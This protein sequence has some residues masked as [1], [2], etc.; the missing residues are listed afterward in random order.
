MTKNVAGRFLLDYENPD[1]GIG[2]S[3]GHINNAYKT[4]MRN[5][6]IFG[7]SRRQLV[8]STKDDWKWKWQQAKRLITG[9][10]LYET[11]NLGNSINELFNF[12]D[13]I[14]ITREKVEALIKEKGLKVIELPKPRIE[15][16]SNYQNDWDVYQEIDQIISSHPENGVVFILPN[17][18]TG[19]FEYASSRD[20]FNQCY[21]NARSR[22]P[23]KLVYPKDTLSIAVHIRRGDLLPGRQ[24]SDLADRMLPDL[25]Y[26]E[27]IQKILN[28]TT[29]KVS[30]IILSEG[31]NGEYRSERG[32]S[33]SWTTAFGSKDVRVIEMIDAPFN[34]SFHQMKSAD[35]LVGSKSGMSHLAGMLSDGIK[36]MPRM[37]HSYRGSKHTIEIEDRKL[38]DQLK[39]LDEFLQLVGANYFRK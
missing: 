8:K 30:V 23:I 16:P 5:N 2:H 36:I 19:D 35:I 17:K 28:V 12:D 39:V 22:I 27:I 15:I 11:H 10:K 20:W 31:V 9:R 26:R 4:C 6:L 34:D 32:E 7:F 1:A 38:S 29:Q 3:L 13:T 33:F 24:F 37:W 18:R 21:S 14:P 25:W